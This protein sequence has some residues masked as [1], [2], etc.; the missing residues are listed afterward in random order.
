LP[1]ETNHKRFAAG[2]YEASAKLNCFLLSKVRLVIFDTNIDAIDAPAISMRIFN[3]GL[4]V[5]W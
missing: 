2:I 1:T 3:D 5:G 4:S